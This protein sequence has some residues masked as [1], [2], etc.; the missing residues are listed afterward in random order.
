MVG[1]VG[2]A[3][4]HHALLEGD[5]LEGGERRVLRRLDADP[6]ADPPDPHGLEAALGEVS[7]DD[8]HQIARGPARPQRHVAVVAQLHHP[9]VE[10]AQLLRGLA[11]RGGA[12]HVAAVALVGHAAV[13]PQGVALLHDPV[14][15]QQADPP[16][17]RA[18]DH[19]QQGQILRPLLE[20]AGAQPDRDLVLGHAGVHLLEDLLLRLRGDLRRPAHV[21]DLARGLDDPHVQDDLRGVHELRPRQPLPD[22]LQGHDVGAEVLLAAQLRADARLAEP[23]GLERLDD[24][25]R[26]PGQPADGPDVLDPSGLFDLHDLEGHGDQD[27]V[28]VLR[29]DEHVGADLVD[30]VLA[31]AVA[32]EV[33]VVQL[34]GDEE[35]V[36]VPL[37]HQGAG[38]GVAVLELLPGEVGVFR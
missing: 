13:E 2:I 33:G 7:F 9:F 38:P 23:H 34:L 16:R 37:G 28:V 26:M 5:V 22:L 29:Q 1:E 6:V 18:G 25:L 24:E 15:G 14:G 27:G 4:E 21:L 8:R 3:R 31:G 17:R 35:R 32:G 36:D 20:Q 19:A 10:L 30:G 12:R 11:H